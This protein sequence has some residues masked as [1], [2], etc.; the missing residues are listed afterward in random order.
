MS[1]RPFYGASSTGHAPTPRSRYEEERDERLGGDFQLRLEVCELRARLSSFE[2]LRR[3]ERSGSLGR[4]GSASSRTPSR[5]SLV[6]RRQELLRRLLRKRVRQCQTKVSDTLRR[7]TS[8]APARRR[9][10]IGGGND[11]SNVQPD[12]LYASVS[13]SSNDIDVRWL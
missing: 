7:A 9:S 6:K 5:L 3:S 4:T 2:T 11:A 8:F 1:S 12:E 10:S 13:C